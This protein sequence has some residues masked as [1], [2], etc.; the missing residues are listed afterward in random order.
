MATIIKLKRGTTTPTT[1][2][3]ANG[4][5]GIDTSAK[6]FYINDSGTIKEIGGGSALEAAALGGD[7]RG[8]T[9]D[10][11]TTTYN[12]SSGADVE[13]VLVFIN[14]VYQRPTTD[15]TVSGSTLTF[16][17][18]PTSGDSITIKELVEG[19]N[20]LSFTDD[21]STVTT[22]NTGETLKIAGGSNVTTSISGDTLTINSTASGNLTVAD[23]SS[24][25][26]T[27][28]IANDTFKIAGGTGITTSLSGD[29][30][31]ITGSAVGSSFT[32]INL[33]DSTNIVA[34]SASDTLNLDSSGLVS[35]TGDA[36][37]DT[38]TV[39]TVSTAAIPF[40]KADGS[41]SNIDLQTSGT[42]GEV[43]Q[44]LYIPF[45]IADGSAVETLVVGSS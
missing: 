36:S 35:I 32:T 4:E 26:T 13:N 44:N 37:T 28:D 39:G 40:L 45:T 43:L 9:G 14:G 31:T 19:I 41:S 33:N 34:D 5:V 15:Y 7:V 38:V 11:S 21:S 20:S 6:K 8:Y 10:G 16:D 23:D 18:A 30:L 29:T 42:I 3:L 25:T 2:D 24:T 22:L 17:T 12:V 1:S 27:L